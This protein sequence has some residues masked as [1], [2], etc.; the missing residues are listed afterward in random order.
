MQC[1][2]KKANKKQAQLATQVI[3]I[4]KKATALFSFVLNQKSELSL[5]TG[6]LY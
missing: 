4:G 2:T 5:C 3:E 1:N 6:S